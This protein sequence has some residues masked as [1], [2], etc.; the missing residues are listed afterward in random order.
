MRHVSSLVEYMH[1][2]QEYAGTCQQFDEQEYAFVHV[3][4]L[5]DLL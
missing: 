5:V 3:S 4:T 1:L 2:S